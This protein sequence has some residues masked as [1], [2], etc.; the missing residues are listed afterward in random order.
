VEKT[1]NSAD[2]I[3]KADK[4]KSES[5][6]ARRILNL[7]HG[8]ITSRTHNTEIIL[9]LFEQ[10]LLRLPGDADNFTNNLTLH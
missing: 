9:S 1:T 10:L 2:E 8:I 4:D 3:I 7:N 6:R 5:G